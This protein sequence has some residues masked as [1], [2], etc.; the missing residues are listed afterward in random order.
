MLLSIQMSDLVCW[1]LKNVYGRE[2]EGNGAKER[3]GCVPEQGCS[4][5]G[6]TRS[7]SLNNL[8]SD[9]HFQQL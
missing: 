1:G 8:L 3:W 4:L 5:G 7:N 6:R 2:E 9:S